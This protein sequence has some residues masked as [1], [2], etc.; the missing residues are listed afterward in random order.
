MPEFFITARSFAAPFFSDTSET[1]VDA[2]TPK[3]ALEVFAESYGHPFGLYAAEAWASADDYYKRQP[4]LAQWLSNKAQTVERATV[5]K[6]GYRF[7]SEHEGHVEINDKT[8]EIGR[9]RDGR[10]VR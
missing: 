1:Y 5:E 4:F 10:V 7:Y 9:P 3:E 2:E 8:Y 6:H